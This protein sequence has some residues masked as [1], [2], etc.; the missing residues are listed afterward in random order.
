MEKREDTVWSLR[1]IVLEEILPLTGRS[2]LELS[3]NI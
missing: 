2:K 3:N 1:E